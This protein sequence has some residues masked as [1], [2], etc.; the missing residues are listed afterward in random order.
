MKTKT[1]VM[2]EVSAKVPALCGHIYEDRDWLWYAGP[3][4]QD[5]PAV[6]EVLK[7]V[8]FRY[9]RNGHALGGGLMGTWGHSCQRPVRTWKKGERGARVEAKEEE[10]VDYVAALAAALEGA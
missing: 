6:R 2:A 9:A 1:E 5:K 7:A 4:L 8:G 10:V 3:S